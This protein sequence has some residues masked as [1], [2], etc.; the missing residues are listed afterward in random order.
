MISTCLDLSKLIP[1]GVLFT[2]DVVSPCETPFL[3]SLLCN[4]HISL[5]ETMNLLLFS[6][7]EINSCLGTSVTMERRT[8]LT[9]R[10]VAVHAQAAELMLFSKLTLLLLKWRDKSSQKKGRDVWMYRTAREKPLIFQRY[11]SA[12]AQSSSSSFKGQLS[13]LF[14]RCSGTGL[15]PMKRQMS[16]IPE[17]RFYL[18]MPKVM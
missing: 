12:L 13:L 16:R 18:T 8:I 17:V 14:R 2:S 11:I 6:R 7:Q 1:L 3:K 4:M 10:K 5:S 15:Q 9:W